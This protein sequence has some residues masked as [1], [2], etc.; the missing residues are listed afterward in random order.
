MKIVLFYLDTDRK[1]RRSQASRFPWKKIGSVALSLIGAALTL[2]QKIDYAASPPV[3]YA[4]LESY[5]TS[6]IGSLHT[7]DAVR[8]HLKRKA[9]VLGSH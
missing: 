9:A 5:R 6:P 7:D 1:R 2:I 8:V 4:R 3:T